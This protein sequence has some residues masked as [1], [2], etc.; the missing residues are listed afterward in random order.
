MICVIKFYESVLFV[1]QVYLYHLPLLELLPFVTYPLALCQ[2]P[3]R[4][5]AKPVPTCPVDTIRHTKPKV[6][7]PLLQISQTLWEKATHFILTCASTLLGTQA[8]QLLLKHSFSKF[9]IVSP[10]FS[11]PCRSICSHW[12]V[13]LLGVLH[14]KADYFL[15]FPADDLEFRFFEST[16]LPPTHPLPNIQHFG[17]SPLPFFFV[18]S[19]V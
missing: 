15:P 13:S 3:S 14:W 12:F 1:P 18:S 17:L 2:H 8:G 5:S 6:L 11:T 4:A 19:C 9:L 7:P 10:I 16:E